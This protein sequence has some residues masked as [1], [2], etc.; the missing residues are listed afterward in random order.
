MW[1][2]VFLLR[3]REILGSV[4][5]DGLVYDKKILVQSNSRLF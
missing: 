3:E 2:L 1:E 5:E 4:E